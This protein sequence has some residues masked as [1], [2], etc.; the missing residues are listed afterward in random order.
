MANQ[1]WCQ[2]WSRYPGSNFAV[3]VNGLEHRF[4]PVEQGGAAES[5]LR[6]NG[7]EVLIFNDLS[8]CVHDLTLFMRIELQRRI[9]RDFR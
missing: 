9:A 1:L 7:S 3:D 5:S 8:H 6:E 4:A 2:S